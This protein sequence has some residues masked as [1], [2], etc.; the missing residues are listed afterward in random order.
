MKFSIELTPGQYADAIAGLT[1]GSIKFKSEGNAKMGEALDAIIRHIVGTFD[2][3]LEIEIE[4]E[5]K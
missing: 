4:K 5:E 1:W 2:V 3:V